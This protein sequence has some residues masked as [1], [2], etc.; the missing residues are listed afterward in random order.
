M[1]IYDLQCA[2]GHTFEGWFQSRG[3]F[4][5]E[6]DAGRLSCPF[7]GDI[8]IKLLPSGGHTSGKEKPDQPMKGPVIGKSLTRFVEENFQDVGERFADEATKMHYGEVDHRNIR[9]TMTREEE[10]TLKEEGIQYLKIPM[11]RYDS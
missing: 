6:K 4:D 2:F 1:I 8:S 7:C 5:R 11:I 3:E 9:G 10:K